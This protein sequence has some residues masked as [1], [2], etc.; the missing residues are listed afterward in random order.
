MIKNYWYIVAFSVVIAILTIQLVYI[1]LCIIF[2]LCLLFLVYQK[3]LS[4]SFLCI[5]IVAFVFYY[6]YSPTVKEVESTIDPK[7]EQQTTFRGKVISSV[8]ETDTK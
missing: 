1:Y 2:F 6:H 7:M 5:C 4:P 8:Q 3:N